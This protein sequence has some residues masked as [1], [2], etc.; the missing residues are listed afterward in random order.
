MRARTPPS[1]RNTNFERLFIQSR[2][3]FAQNAAPAG[4]RLSK[5]AFDR[6]YS[7]LEEEHGREGLTGCGTQ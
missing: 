5:R 6:M 2:H 7:E 4:G 1:P 3:G